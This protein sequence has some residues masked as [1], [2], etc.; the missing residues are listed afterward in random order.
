MKFSKLLF[1]YV[2][3]QLFSS[4]YAQNIESIIT[5]KAR[6][7]PGDTVFFQLDFDQNINSGVLHVRYFHLGTVIDEVEI[8]VIDNQL[9]NWEYIPVEDD[10]KGYLAEVKFFV[11]GHLLDRDNIAFDVS[12]E[13]TKFP[14]YG[15]LSDY[16]ILNSGLRD[17]VLSNLNRHHINGL[18][19]Y[20]WQNKHHIPLDGTPQSPAYSWKNIFNRTVYYWTV[21]YYIEEA[22]T[23]NIKS[24]NYNLLYGA[25]SDASDDG[26]SDEW[27][28]FE[29]NQ[30][31]TP[32]FH[33]LPDSWESDIYLINPFN[34]D[35]K[36][37]LFDKE[38]DAFEALP[39][40]GWHIDQLGN[41]GTVYDYFGNSLNLKNS[42]TPFISEAKDFLDKKMV[43]NAVGQYG[44]AEISQAPVEFLY[45]EHWDDDSYSD[46][47]DIIKTNSSYS[48]NSLNTVLAAYMN[49][50]FGQSTGY[51]NTPGILYTDAVIFSEG[52]AHLELGE[53]MLHN[54]FFPA[55]NLQMSEELTASLVDYYDFLTAYQNI[56]RDSVSN[57]FLTLTSDIS[58]SN[59]VK[60]GSVWKRVKTKDEMDIIHLIN[61]IGATHTRWKD[62]NANQTAPIIQKDFEFNIHS[63]KS[64]GRIW[65]ASPDT[66]SGSPV[67]LP[68]TE[69]SGVYTISVPYLEYW[70]MIVVEYGDQVGVEKNNGKPD[71]FTLGQNFPNPFNPNTTVEFTISEPGT[72]K[73]GVIDILGQEILTMN[74]HYN[75][76]GNYHINI[77]A[78]NLSSGVYWYYM[79]QNENVEVRKMMVLK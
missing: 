19:Y 51:F 36:N 72:V 5:D 59:F 1:F 49:Y 60:T 52:G 67:S 22:N 41:Q 57:G 2:I 56:L 18:Q 46:I 26:V 71:K 17:D 13:W 29:D 27:R 54:E 15:F 37:Y 73:F 7:I 10:F 6:Y 21:R 45:T 65:M 38:K 76:A 61:F 32:K 14:R 44:Q 69:S 3:I 24:M 75:F 30:H 16:T 58:L 28:I 62:K 42:Y 12:S 48:Q 33:D 50:D 34:Q 40:D 78:K 63:S 35:W 64:I 25:Y 55:N 47:A 20:D 77:S 43:M 11:D 9:L 68:F 8:E 23:Y 53:H 4:F 66:I 39:F 74:T 70:T 79:R 31:L